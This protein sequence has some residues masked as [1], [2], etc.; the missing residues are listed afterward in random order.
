MLMWIKRWLH[1]ARIVRLGYNVFKC[2]CALRLLLLPMLSGTIL[3]FGMCRSYG[4]SDF[5][6]VSWFV[7]SIQT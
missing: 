2:A 1:V 4:S 3:A 6:C 7:A 5:L